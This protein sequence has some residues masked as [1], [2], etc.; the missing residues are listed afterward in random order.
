MDKGPSVNKREL[1]GASFSGFS[2]LP[3][4]HFVIRVRNNATPWLEWVHKCSNQCKKGWV[5]FE[6]DCYFFSNNIMTFKDAMVTC[7]NMGGALLD[8]Q[9]KL[10]ENWLYL[11]STIRGYHQGFW[12][13]ISDMQGEKHFVAI[14]NGRKPHYVHW[15]GGEPNNSGGSEDCTVYL[16]SRKAWN[17]TKCSN[18]AIS[19]AKNKT[20]HAGI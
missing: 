18:K 15:S 5:E 12:L 14:S 16:L 10:E 20:E 7:Y 6:R 8:L 17:D 13:G 11:H 1:R 2:E 9:N 19:F 3:L 4:I